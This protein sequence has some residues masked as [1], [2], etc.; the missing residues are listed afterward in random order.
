MDIVTELRSENPD[1]IINNIVQYYE[2]IISHMP[3]NVY[4]L[5]KQCRAVGCNKNVLDMMGLKS[6]DE[7]KGLTFEQ[8]G[9]VGNWSDHATNSF[10]EDSLK[11]IKNGVAKL[12]IEEPPIPHSNGKMIYFLTSRV[13]IFDKQNNIIGLVGISVDI[14]EIK[15]AQLTLQ[16]A[17]TQA[18]IASREKS[19]F[20]ANMSHDVKTPLSG[21]I[22]ISELL[23]KR[24][25]GE[26][27]E[28]VE[29][30]MTSGKQ[31]SS[32]FDNCL[33]VF[34]IETSD[35]SIE[36]VHFDIKNLIQE[37]EALFHPAIKTKEL[38]FEIIYGE[39]IPN[40]MY[41]SRPGLYRILLN[42]LSNAVK[43][44]NHG[45]VKIVINTKEINNQIIL[46]VKVSDSGIGIPDD[47]Q[48][49][50]FERFA[51]LT[52]SHKGVY[53]GSGIGLFIVQKFVKSMGGE[54]IL[55]SKE[56]QGSEFTVILPFKTSLVE[57]RPEPFKLNL[58]KFRNLQHTKS[59]KMPDEIFKVLLVEDN[60]IAQRLQST[61]L[62]SL[63]CEVDIASNDKQALELF[64]PG[65]YDLI[66]IDI[67]L[68]DLSGDKV[69]KII[70]E[71]EQDTSFHV[72][73]IALTAHLDEQA[74]PE[75]FAAGVDEV[76][77]KPLSYDQ[78]KEIIDYLS[79]I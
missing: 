47:K 28:L 9:K 2:S 77:A 30:L 10:R 60:L 39:N 71:R 64:L 17:K 20:I 54:I 53:E 43:F 68:P 67:G 8:M 55:N 78:T 38:F 4:W 62:N 19:E 32:F 14:S 5:D 25:R 18:E 48:K 36:N 21:I 76:Y 70:R 65:K 23:T 57:N 51:K 61:T 15:Q 1:E 41:G 59:T 79:K 27:L 31:L 69:T 22:G 11:V 3:G 75:Y 16:A 29:M 56:Q 73:V 26:D 44:T 72:P 24:L 50:I 42:L 49:V 58:S 6:I 45:F 12:N 52:P 37:L 34:R 33:E 40:F 7:F 63:N 35:V 66:L 74:H 13:P 46:E